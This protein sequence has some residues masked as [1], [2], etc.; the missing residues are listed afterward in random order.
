MSDYESF[1]HG[2][3]DYP[4]TAAT[5]NSLLRDAD[6]ALYY[7]LEYLAGVLQIDIGARLT[8]Q[9]ALEGLVLSAAVKQK[10]HLE[11]SPFIYADQ[12]TFPTLAIYRKNETYSEKSISFDLDVSEWEFAYVLPP[13][14]P[15]QQQQLQ[16]ILRAA[17][18]SIRHAVEQGYHPLYNSGQKVWTDA[19]I[20]AIKVVG[21]R[22]GGY[23]PITDGGGTYRAL[24]GS[25]QVMERSM[26]RP[27]SFAELAGVDGAIDNVD[28]TDAENPV[29]DVA[30]FDADTTE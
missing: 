19:G 2:G 23:E 28:P 3:V 1:K 30:Q 10:I 20:S 7:A 8:A 22:Y 16:P 14:T 11:P 29:A 5:A 12:L 17:A 21:V 13:L 27:A 6:P 9:A 4:L 26:P 18:V 15:R 24:V 25:M